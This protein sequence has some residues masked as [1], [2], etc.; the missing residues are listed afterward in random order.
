MFCDITNF[1]SEYKY[2]AQDD[3][4]LTPPLYKFFVDPLL[5]ILPWQIPANIITLFSNS[6]VT[7]SFI[8]AYFEYR[9]NSYN[10]WWLIPLL[11]FIYVIGDCTDGKQARR[12]GTGSPLGEFLDHYLDTYVS[13]MLF[14]V[15]CFSFHIENPILIFLGFFSFYLVQASTFWER[16]KTGLMYFGKLSSTESILAIVI[17]A[18]FAANEGIRTWAGTQLFS[19]FGFDFSIIETLLT[20]IFLAPLGS[21]ISTLTRAKPNA[22]FSI[23]IVFSIITTIFTLTC[24]S[25]LISTILITMYNALFVSTLLIA[26]NDKQKKPWVEIIIP[27]FLVLIKILHVYFPTQID[28]FFPFSFYLMIGILAILHLFLFFTFFYQ[29]RDRWVWKN[30]QPMAQLHEKEE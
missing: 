23:F 8:I 20:L 25:L 16:Y 14:G 28:S 10:F 30:P 1:M 13:G 4:L 17:F 5:K 2:R 22:I 21:A 12:T 11:V 15:L 6:L 7:I 26:T 3:S 19:I 24:G 29:Y 9:N 27:A 18:S